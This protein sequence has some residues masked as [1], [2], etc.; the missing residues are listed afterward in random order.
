[1]EELSQ[2]RICRLTDWIILNPGD[3]M[4]CQRIIQEEY[5]IDHRIVKRRVEKYHEKMAEEIPNQVIIF[6]ENMFLTELENL[7]LQRINVLFNNFF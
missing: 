4:H 7:Y 1:V 6:L 2:Y 3:C 5:L